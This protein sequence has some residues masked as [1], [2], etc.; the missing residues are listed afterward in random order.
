MKKIT[1]VAAFMFVMIALVCEKSKAQSQNDPNQQ[2]TNQ[3]DP[4]A[5]QATDPNATQSTD[6]STV[7]IDSTATATPESVPVE[8]T[9]TKSESSTSKIHIYSGKHDGNN[10]I[11]P[12]PKN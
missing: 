3:T 10:V 6:P 9:P 8:S 1:L 4:N 2:S 11:N 12:D 5:T 7:N